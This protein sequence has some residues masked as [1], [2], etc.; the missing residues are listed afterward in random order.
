MITD[1]VRI[2]EGLVNFL[3]DLI[4]RKNSFLESIWVLIGRNS[5][6]RTEIGL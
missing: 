2:L 3:G 5:S 1:S 6:L 4:A